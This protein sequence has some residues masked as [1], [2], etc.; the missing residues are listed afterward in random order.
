MIQPAAEIIDVATARFT[1]EY[2]ASH[3]RMCATRATTAMACTPE[4][5][6]KF[7]PRT[8]RQAGGM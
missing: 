2:Q 7:L 1:A 3:E 6:Q 5:L 8:H 4:A